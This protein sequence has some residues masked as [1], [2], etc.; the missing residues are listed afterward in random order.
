MCHKCL[1]HGTGESPHVVVLDRVL[2]DGVGKRDVEIRAFCVVN[3]GGGVG[4]AP[5]GIE[6]VCRWQDVLNRRGDNPDGVCKL[7]VGD[8]IKSS[9]GRLYH[10]LGEVVVCVAAV[11]KD[12]LGDLNASVPERSADRSFGKDVTV[13][14]V[15]RDQGHATGAVRKNELVFVVDG[16]CEWAVGVLCK[17]HCVSDAVAV[18]H[19][20]SHVGFDG[21]FEASSCCNKVFADAGR[22]KQR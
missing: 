8:K 14:G 10:P 20:G 12:V 22:E 18:V 6:N 7:G 16:V 5:V 19:D 11:L 21:G 17:G 13:V 2:C 1:D 15:E 3:N 9:G 4:A